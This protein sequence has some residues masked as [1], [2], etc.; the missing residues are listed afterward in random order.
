MATNLFTP[1]SQIPQMILEMSEDKM[2]ERVAHIKS[3]L[4]SKLVI[5]GHHYQRDEVIQFADYTGDS[6]KLAQIAAE[7]KDAKTIVFCGV[8]FMAET[9]DI[10][11]DDHQQVVLPDLK[12]GCSMADMANIEQ[13]EESWEILTELF[14]DT[15]LPLT[16]VNS[17]AH[18]KSFCGEHGGATCT[19]SNAGNM[20]RW[21]F[22]AKKRILFLPDEHLG[23]NT[24]CYLGI[25]AEQMAVWNP[26]TAK[27]EGV[28]GELDDIKV[29]L[30]KGFCSVHQKFASEHVHRIRE[31]HPDMK[32]IVHPE[33]SY[34]VVQ[35]A[36]DH[37]STEYI[38]KQIQAAP[39]GSE[40][41]VGTE[42]NLVRRLAKQY[43][44]QKIVLLN[45]MICPCLTMNRI[46]LPHLLWSLENCMNEQVS[47]VV[48]VPR[49]TAAFARIA[50]ERMLNHS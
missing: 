29:I 26:I 41:A 43:P 18:I 2:S 22:S 47:N 11:T 45:E 34:E 48:K 25:P 36:D 23:R 31:K 9:A 1:S 27:L 6:L 24:S 50:L 33:C 4:G 32:V 37:G 17:T 46:D 28:Q 8:H 44:E 3:V 35:L 13:L 21:G 42:V 19:S 40:W 12:A 16:Y 39:P 49:E 30:W 7:L 5:L 15:L 10:L 38:I 14:G 20:F